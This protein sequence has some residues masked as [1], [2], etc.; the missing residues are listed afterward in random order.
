MPFIPGLYVQLHLTPNNKRKIVVKIANNRHD[1]VLK[2]LNTS[3]NSVLSFGSNLDLKANYHLTCLQNDDQYLTQILS[4]DGRTADFNFN[5]LEDNNEY[6]SEI[7]GASY[8]V[9][10]GALKTEA[11]LNGKFSVVEDGILVQ[12][13]PNSLDNLKNALKQKMNFT[14]NCG[15]SGSQS[16][17]KNDQQDESVSIE[18]TEDDLQFN[19]G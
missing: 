1:L 16:N 2:A 19:L 18:F 15:S 6:I 7:I 12:L 11:G 9:F 8:I 14:L 13:L 4:R 3:S 10:S 17:G 5:N